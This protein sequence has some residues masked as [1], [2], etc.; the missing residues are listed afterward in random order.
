MAVFPG[1]P[2]YL[3]YT[4]GGQNMG[5]SIQPNS[6]RFE[7]SGLLRP[8]T[9]LDLNVFGRVT[10]HGNASYG[11]SSG[12]GTNLTPGMSAANPLTRRAIRFPR[13]SSTPGS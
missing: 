7:V 13:V 11:I 2:N 8:V 12:D 5:P 4:N 9:Y 10:L 6:L 3:N 1:N